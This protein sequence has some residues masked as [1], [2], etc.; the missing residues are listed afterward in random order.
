MCVK[1][2]DLVSIKT[3]SLREISVHQEFFDSLRE[4]PLENW[5]EIGNVITV[6]NAKDENDFD[7][8]PQIINEVLNSKDLEESRNKVVN[9]AW[10]HKGESAKNIVDYILSK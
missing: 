7:K 9:E 8:M 6:V 10:H 2:I 3:V 5:Y 1:D 4:E